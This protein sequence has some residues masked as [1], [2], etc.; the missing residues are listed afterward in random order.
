MNHFVN[1]CKKQK[2]K[3][4]D[5][6][7]LCF[8]MAGYEIEWKGSQENEVGIDAKTGKVLVAVNPKFYRPAEVEELLGDATK[9]KKILKWE[10]K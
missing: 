7:T 9:A 8:T 1:N 10:P 2:R 6:C 4:R 5:F 3:V